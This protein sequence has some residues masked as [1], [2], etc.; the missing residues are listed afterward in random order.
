MSN[1][2]TVKFTFENTDYWITTQCLDN[3]T[4]NRWYQSAKEVYQLPPIINLNNHPN[5]Q[6]AFNKKNNQVFIN[7][8][9][10]ELLSA[11][12]DFK[13]IGVIWPDEEPT[14]FNYDQ[15]WC[16][17]IHR[18]FTT[19]MQYR[20][21]NI[22]SVEV[23]KQ[24]DLNISTFH[25]LGHVVNDCIH[26][27][28]S[29]CVNQTRQKYMLA[30]KAIFVNVPG[31]NP[32]PNK[33]HTWHNFEPD[34][35]QYHTWA[36]EYDVIFDAEILGKTTF[37]SFG[38]EDNPNYFDTSGHHGWYGSFLILADDTRSKIYAGD[39]FNNWLKSHGVSKDS[40]NIRGDFP[41]GKVIA[42]SD[43][44]FRT[45][46]RAKNITNCSVIFHN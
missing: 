33:T 35:Y 3:P 7:K 4:I 46:E 34:D 38:D 39:D 37:C 20:R 28:E 32:D 24:T 8:K 10:N 13:K 18:Y 5:H 22:N 2:F 27:I 23:I 11:I 30:S 25:N 41:I 26:Q 45:I 29:Y 42:A 44:D 36:G 16:N 6:S 9:Y 43:P 31:Y 1:K 21:F 14:E 15:Q 19:L 17:K 40:P 12:D